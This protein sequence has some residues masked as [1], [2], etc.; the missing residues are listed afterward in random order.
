VDHFMA[1]SHSPNSRARVLLIA[2]LAILAVAACQGAPTDDQTTSL[3]TASGMS[4]VGR[5]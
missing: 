2:V 1:K 3:D 5:A 4:T